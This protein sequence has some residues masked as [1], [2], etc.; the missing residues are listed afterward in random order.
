MKD[1]GGDIPC[2]LCGHQHHV[3]PKQLQCYLQILFVCS[4]C[5]TEVLHENAVAQEIADQV[6][7]ME[8]RVPRLKI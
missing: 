7:S 5:Q 8:W 4:N 2:P 3:T 1:Y 6:A